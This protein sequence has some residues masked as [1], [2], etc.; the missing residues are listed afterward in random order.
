MVMHHDTGYKELFSH[1]EFVEALLV[2]FV[3][4]SISQL[5]DYSTL[6]SQPNHYITPLFDEKIEDAVW[7]VKFRPDSDMQQQTLYLY[8]LLEFQSGVD[9]IM[10]LRMLHY[11]ASFYHQLLKENKLAA[12]QQL[13]AVFPVVLYNGKPRW[14]P[15]TSMLDMLQPIP[16]FLQRF[17]PQLDYH[18]VDVKDCIPAWDSGHDNLLQLVFNIENAMTAEDMQRVARD[19][20]DAVRKHPDRERIDR[21]LVRWFKRFLYQNRITIDLDAVNQLQEIPPMLAD[22]VDSWF[23]QW[24]QEGIAAGRQVGIQ[25]GIREGIQQG[26]QQGQQQGRVLALRQTLEKQLQLKFGSLPP[27]Y[28]QR[29]EQADSSELELW[30]ERILFADSVETLFS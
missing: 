12:G 1:P 8:I 22:R 18:L 26:I 3:P 29:I 14:T 17:Q 28:L 5:L 11:S 15:P 4:Q 13:P 23:E 9:R 2:G 21:V 10:P 25:E 24:K 19:I 20:A 6:T 7:S 16:S 30:T 27:E